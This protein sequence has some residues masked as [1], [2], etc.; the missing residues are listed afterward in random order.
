MS[1]VFGL[2]SRYTPV[3]NETSRVVFAYDIEP[4]DEINSIWREVFFYKKQYPNLTIDDVKNA[5]ISGINAETDE[6]ILNG[7]VWHNIN[8]WLSS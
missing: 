6:K 2:T 5:I 3:S 8:V 4:V 7:F 1:K